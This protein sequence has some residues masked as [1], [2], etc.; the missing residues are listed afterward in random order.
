M[1]EGADAARKAAV[2]LGL[3][4]IIAVYCRSSTLYQIH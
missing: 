3:G 1:A 4:R 2:V